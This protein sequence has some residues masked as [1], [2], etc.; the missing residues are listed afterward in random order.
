M[1]IGGDNKPAPDPLPQNRVG[2]PPQENG[3]TAVILARSGSLLT[4][5]VSSFC[6]FFRIFPKKYFCFSTA[7]PKINF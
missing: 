4:R 7:P 1:E 6:F 3:E 2:S 5:P